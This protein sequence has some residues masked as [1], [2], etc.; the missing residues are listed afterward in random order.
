MFV[1]MTIIEFAVAA[2]LIIGLFN[3]DKVVAF[4]DKIIAII[5]RKIKSRKAVATPYRSY[6]HQNDHRNCA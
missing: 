6:K 4:E 3:E 5:K 2:L 1:L